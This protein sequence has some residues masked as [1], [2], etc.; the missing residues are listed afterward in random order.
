MQSFSMWTTET[1]I[2]D[3][4]ADL[5]HWVHILEGTFS[6]VATHVFK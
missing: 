3:A 6:H 2:L 1:L 5:S 4:Q